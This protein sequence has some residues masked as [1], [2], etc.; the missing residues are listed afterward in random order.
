MADFGEASREDVVEKPSDE[1]FGGR[2]D[3]PFLA[4]VVVVPGEESDG[5][6]GHTH[7]AVVG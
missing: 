7:E 1:F 5:S 4:G 3:G 2:G 6:V